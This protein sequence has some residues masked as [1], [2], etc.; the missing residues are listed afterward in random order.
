[1]TK[2]FITLFC[3]T[4]VGAVLFANNLTFDKSKAI[5]DSGK[6]EFTATSV[7]ETVKD[8]KTG[9]NLGNTFDAIG[10]TDLSSETS[11]GQPLTTK[12]MIEGLANSGIKTIR[13]PVSWAGHI[14]DDKY[15]IDPKWMSRVKEV[16]D[17]AIAE[18]MY[19]ILNTHHD[20]FSHNSKMPYGKGYYPTTENYEESS[21]FLCNVW[22]QISLAF[23]NGYDQHLIFETMNE[24]RPAGTKEEWYFNKNSSLGRDVAVTIN[25][26]NQDILDTIRAAGGNNMKRYVSCPGLAASPDSALDSAFVMPKDS[27][28][29][30][31]IVSV[32]MYTPYNFAMES[33]GVKSF[34]AIMGNDLAKMF[35]RLNDTF[36]AKGY[37]V[38]IGEYGATNKNNLE[39]RVAWF[40]FF[41]KYS[42]LYGMTSCL[43]DNG[44]WAVKGNDYS[45]HYGYYNRRE[46][47]WFFPEILEA[48]QEETK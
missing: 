25:K 16:V 34:N 45:E 23:N 18:D 28:P 12:P 36:I 4:A 3:L 33:P 14:I 27:E 48:I 11:W 8:M 29:G 43:W 46:Q 47:K 35:K 9:W 2:R 17:W 44:V 42:R 15:T 20:N 31:L 24:P 10:R 40:H 39:D 7:V 30:K 38:I 1:M 13:I 32:H 22:G 5:V 19:V 26:L 41:L 6:K 37:P 21:K